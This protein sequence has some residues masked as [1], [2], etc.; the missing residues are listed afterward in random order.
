AHH[1]TIYEIDELE[2][3]YNEAGFSKWEVFE[4]HGDMIG[5]GWVD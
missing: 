4:H 3:D 5:I 2:K 1:Y